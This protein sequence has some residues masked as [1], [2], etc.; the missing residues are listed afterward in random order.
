MQQTENL[1]RCPG[2]KKEVAKY[3]G[4]YRSSVTEVSMT[5][6]TFSTVPSI[7]DLLVNFNGSFLIGQWDDALRCAEIQD[8]GDTI[9]LKQDISYCQDTTSEFTSP[10]IPRIYHSLELIYEP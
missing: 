9:I 8:S 2:Q 3:S 4:L 6:K 5:K 10:D 7:L 1:K